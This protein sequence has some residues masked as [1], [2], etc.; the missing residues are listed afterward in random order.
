M[1]YHQ[2]KG[3]AVYVHFHNP[4]TGKNPPLP[5]SETRHLDGATDEQIKAWIQNYAAINGYSVQNE[6]HVIGD[7]WAKLIAGFMATPEVTTKDEKT[8]GDYKRY[9]T[10]YVLVYFVN[11]LQLNDPYQWTYKSGALTT[12]LVNERKVSGYVVKK[13]NVALRMFWDYLIDTGE[14]HQS[15]SLRLKTV[16]IPAPETPLERVYKPEDI[17]NIAKKLEPDLRLMLLCGYFMSIR[18]QELFALKA[19]T[20]LAGIRAV[21]IECSK[22][23][24]SAGL[25]QGLVGYIKEQR[26]QSGKIRKPKGGIVAYVACF[27]K[28]AAEQIVKL[29][30]VLHNPKEEYL[31]SMPNDHYFKRWDDYN[32][33]LTVKDTRRSSLYWLGHNSK[34]TPVAI[35]NHARH[36]KMET[37]DKY[38]RRPKE[39]LDTVDLVL[40][41]TLPEEGN[42]NGNSK[43]G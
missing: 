31:Y 27:D 5:R 3:E 39:T 36:K 42:A 35:K 26:T 33:G 8:Q 4:E 24:K 32:L 13:C 9:L 43:A 15:I 2:R 28:D 23:M 12:Y 22:V 14:M 21:E 41:L 16:K 20:F 38:L 30:Q 6:E 7:R 29:V 37:T 25:Y 18:P 17:F 1:G 19:T 11:K 10:Q 34:L 40:D